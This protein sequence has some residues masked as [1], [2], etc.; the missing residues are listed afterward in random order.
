M[1]EAE[2]EGKRGGGGG[3]EESN[4]MEEKDVINYCRRR[5]GKGIGKWWEN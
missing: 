2:E 1:G 4:E 5:G 3:Y